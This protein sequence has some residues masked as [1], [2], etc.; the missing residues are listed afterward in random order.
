MHQGGKEYGLFTRYLIEEMKK[1][2]YWKSEHLDG[3]IH[4][5]LGANYDGRVDDRG[6]VR[7]YGEEA[8][9][10]IRWRPTCRTP[11][12]S[13]PSGRRARRAATRWTT[14]A[15]RSVSGAFGPA[16]AG[17]RHACTPRTRRSRAR[18][19]AATASPPTRAGRAVTPSRARADPRQVEI[20]EQYGK[21]LAQAVGALDT[22]LGS[23]LLGWSDQ[24]F[25]SYGQ[26]THWNSHG[27][28]ADG[29]R[30]ST[31]WLAMT[32]RNRWARGDLVAVEA[33]DVPTA[34][35][36]QEAIPLAGAYAFHNGTR[37]SIILLSRSL[38]ET[39]PVRLQLP[40]ARAKSI[41]LHT[42]AGNPRD[43]NREAMRVD[44]KSETVPAGAL[45]NGRLTV[46][47]GL[48]PGGI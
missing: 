14:P 22:W 21:S 16:C 46:K 9:A 40:F 43:T 45:N 36:G 18:G 41:T 47:D 28:F 24:C 35:R 31:G 5:T 10:E 8:I 19:R 38:G 6:R 26:G 1:S 25:F 33:S 20:N 42:L 17:R 23:D 11:T 7:G 34:M 12:M 37:W 48:P 32:L 27:V 30:P 2:P 44:L 15:T 29:F 3:K 4:F 39:I 13:V